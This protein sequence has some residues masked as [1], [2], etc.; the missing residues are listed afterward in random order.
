MLTGSYVA[1][2][3]SGYVQ[4]QCELDS[5]LIQ[6]LTLAEAFRMTSNA[7]VMKACRRVE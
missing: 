6:T 7:S 1:Y 4:G 3:T 5:V 2:Q